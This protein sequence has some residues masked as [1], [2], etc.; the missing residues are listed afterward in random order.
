MIPS[1][2]LC[3]HCGAR[4]SSPAEARQHE[5]TC[6]HNPDRMGRHALIEQP[7]DMQVYYGAPGPK[8]ARP[9]HPDPLAHYGSQ[10]RQSEMARGVMSVAFAEMST[11]ARGLMALGVRA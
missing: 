1:P 2:T 3:A 7:S 8:H 6:P 9:E 10:A 4:Y 11:A 5:A